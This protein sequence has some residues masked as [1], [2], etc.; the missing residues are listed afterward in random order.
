MFFFKRLRTVADFEDRDARAGQGQQVALSLLKDGQ[1]QNGGARRKVVDAIFH[2]QILV[3]YG[4]RRVGWSSLRNRERMNLRSYNNTTHGEL[5]KGMRPQGYR[6]FLSTT[7]RKE[8]TK[9]VIIVPSGHKAFGC[10]TLF[11]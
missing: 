8:N 5:R 9:Q 3:Q 1:G 11:G 2:V 4:E 10:S 7:S 6:M